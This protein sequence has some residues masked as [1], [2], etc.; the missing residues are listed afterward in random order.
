MKIAIS[1]KG[2]CG[3]ST[4]TVLLSKAFS[5]MGFNVTVVDVD[6]SNVGLSKMLGLEEGGKSLMELLGGREEFRRA[7]NKGLPDIPS[8]NHAATTRDRVRL[9]K[10]GKIERGGEGCACLMGILAKEVL[11]NVRDEGDLIIVDMD[12]GIEHLGRGVDKAVDVLLFVV[13]PTYDSVVLAERASKMAA[14][15]GI[16]RFAAVLNKVDDEAANI[17][18]SK[19]SALGVR[20]IGVIRQD[21]KIARSALTGEAIDSG[22]AMSD[23]MALASALLEEVKDG[24]GG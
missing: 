13:D 20:I 23:A 11:S 15:L 5:K 21:P 10:V 3:K 4:L 17:L 12:A 18:S 16:K 1:G 2:G 6:E 9:V 19:L 7:L 24:S 14:E 22:A 8:L